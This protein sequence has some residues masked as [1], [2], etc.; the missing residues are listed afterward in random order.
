MAEAD[1]PREQGGEALHRWR[2]ADMVL[3]E[4]SLE[5]QRQGQPLRLHRKLMQVLLH[6]L[7]H[8]GEVV[9]KDELAEACWPGRIPSD[10]VLSTTLNRL[11]TVLGDEHQTLIKTVHGYGYRLQAAVTVELVGDERPSHLQLQAGE[12]P[13]LRPTWTLVERLG[14]S[15]EVWKVRQ[16]K[17][18]EQ[19]V[20]KFA[21]DGRGLR[22][23][24]R[25]ITLFRVLKDALGER[26]DLVR[27]LDWNIEQS[28]FFVEMEYLPQGSLLHWAQSAAPP[29]ALRLEL[30]AQCAEALA[31]AHGVGVLHKDLKPANVLIVAEAGQ[32]PQIKLSDF[33]IGGVLDPARLQGITR[34]GFTATV[35]AQDSSGTPLYLAPEMQ[36]GQPATVQGD[37][38]ALGVMLYQAVVGD[39]K[40]PLAPGWEREIDD[41]VLR[42]DIAAAVDGDP[43]R[44]LGD[45]A[46]L[47]R[48]LRQ[49][50]QRRLFLHQ[51][52]AEALR[53]TDLQQRLQRVEA[54][55]RWTLALAVA[56]LLGLA[57]TLVLYAQVLGANRERS[58]ALEQAQREAEASRQLSDYVIS[59]FDA[60]APEAVEGRLLEPRKLVDRGRDELAA[61][62]EGQPLVR[63]RML[64]TLGGLYCKMGL[65]ED[66]RSQTEQALAL[67]EATAGADPLLSAELLQQLA[68]A[69]TELGQYGV[70]EQHLRRALALQEPRL[71]A[72]DPRLAGTLNKLGQSLLQQHRTRESLAVLERARTLLPALPADAGEKTAQLSIALLGALADTLYDAG[73]HGEALALAQQRITRAQ[74]RYGKTHLRSYEALDGYA[75]L[76]WQAGRHAEA[77]PVQREAVEGYL[78]IYGH[79][80]QPTINAHNNLG[81]ILNGLGRVR[82]AAQWMQLAVEAMRARGS[83]D[84]IEYALTLG[85]LSQVQEQSGDY[86][87]AL[88]NL[89]EAYALV[90]SHHGD[91]G[92]RTHLQRISLGRMLTLVGQPEQGLALL[93]PEVPATLE[94]EQA[95][96]LRGRRLR[97]IGN[98]QLALGRMA[99]ASAAYDRAE[100]HFRGFLPDGH[101]IFATIE[102]SRGQM[103]IGQRRYAEALP[104]LEH[105]IAGSERHEHPESPA[106]LVARIA[107]A[108]A[109]AGLGRAG[110]AQASLR[111]LQAAAERELAPAHPARR[112]LSRLL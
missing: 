55:R 100:A 24:K 9:T 10:T 68:G 61:R 57:S 112:E 79:E 4:R 44:R 32:A 90:R 93:Q 51:E 20:C 64:A 27:I 40:K 60:A 8:A 3:D 76:L 104:V 34:L 39:W 73:R 83:S 80:G 45:A 71:A 67:Q 6:L 106:V 50:E 59:L 52:R 22:A 18:G 48:R 49:L 33:G 42:A 19:R 38:Y 102:L 72:A 110:E 12:H 92:L 58:A 36:A 85:N 69:V 53:Q 98:S 16:D 14:D 13:P 88:P 94:G 25:E 23:I 66:C 11:R 78:R 65:P 30:L 96:V 75:A 101:R 74:A 86:A 95:Q 89:R 31:A 7:Q 1:A 63:A 37:I 77:V 5:L 46:E 2:F 15:G 28:P 105:A 41:E 47:A 56:L 35:A 91:D 111:Q 29:L 108:S 43:A 54:R 21:S 82:E 62:F 99:L 87:T 103:L 107:R 81:A 26:A 70:A 17:T 109:L 84:S 97:E